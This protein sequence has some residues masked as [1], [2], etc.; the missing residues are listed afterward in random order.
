MASDR[1]Y[2]IFLAVT[3]AILF[4]A[5]APLSKVLLGQVDPVLLA[6]LLYLGSGA[7][8]LLF[9]LIGGMAGM[10][11]GKPLARADA[12]WLAGA[13]I[14]GGVAAPDTVNGRADEHSCR[15]RI[16]FAEF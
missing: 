5:S 14:A 3:G 1:V 16:S 7:G 4:G 9:K 12:P 6:A 8:L 2:P 11:A 15:D 13:V 10:Q